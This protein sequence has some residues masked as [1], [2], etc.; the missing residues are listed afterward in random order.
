MKCLGKS[1]LLIC[2][3]SH[4]LSLFT[5]SFPCHQMV[6]RIS[7][8]SESP[9]RSSLS[10]GYGT[11]GSCKFRS[12]PGSARLLC[13]SDH[14]IQESESWKGPLRWA[15]IFQMS[16]GHGRPRP[17]CLP[18][19]SQGWDGWLGAGWVP[20]SPAGCQSVCRNSGKGLRAG[21]RTVHPSQ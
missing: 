1:E 15:C 18:G 3:Y 13:E 19:H 20:S 14:G 2:L 8:T 4:H 21:W 11:P 7:T 9:P 10:Q 5:H 17:H 12:R 16:S 6:R